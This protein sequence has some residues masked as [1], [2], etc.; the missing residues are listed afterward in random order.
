MKK[1]R[2][3]QIN[4]EAKCRAFIQSVA[5]NLIA[6]IPKRKV[7]DVALIRS[8]EA[9]DKECR[10][11]GAL[12][13]FKMANL[14]GGNSNVKDFVKH[15]DFDT[16]NAYFKRVHAAIRL[17]AEKNGV[18]N[19]VAKEICDFNLK[20]ETS[21]S[22]NEKQALL[23]YNLTLDEYDPNVSQSKDSTHYNWNGFW[24]LIET[25][26]GVVKQA[27]LSDTADREYFYGFIQKPN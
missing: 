21:F 16:I 22:F 14:L 6:S 11:R 23:A 19:E 1:P 8:F 5:D 9:I 20:E 13:L 27:F 2:K 26:N 24:S 10:Q 25:K 12:Q 17:D 18:L 4:T 7:S 15:R 3:N